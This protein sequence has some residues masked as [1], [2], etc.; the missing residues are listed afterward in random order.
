MDVD[1]AY[2]INNA[3]LFFPPGAGSSSGNFAPADT[4][5]S[6]AASPNV[7]AS[8][9]IEAHIIPTLQLGIDAL[10]G[11]IKAN[12][13]VNFDS[14]AKLALSLQA[15]AALSKS[16]NNGSSAASSFS[17][18]VDVSTTLGVNAAADA[19][20]PGIFDKDVSVPL[21]SKT[22]DLFNVSGALSAC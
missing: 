5:L 1:L 12:V 15:S 13:N 7:A 9:S 2:N 21:F 3:K 16:K 17:G 8:G 14:S 20:F 22:F 6:L 4:G 18:C 19:A 10:D 11:K